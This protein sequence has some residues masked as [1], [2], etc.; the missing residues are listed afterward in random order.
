MQKLFFFLISDSFHQ[1]ILYSNKD[2]IKQEDLKALN[3]VCDACITTLP[4]ES[5]MSCEVIL[6]KP[7][8][9]VIRNTEAYELTSNLEVQKI[10]PLTTKSNSTT[11]KSV[12][13]QEYDTNVS[14]KN[15]KTQINEGKIHYVPDEN[16]DWDDEDP[17]D[18]LTCELENVRVSSSKSKEDNEDD[19]KITSAQTTFKL[20][21][22]NQ[23]RIAK[24]QLLLPHTR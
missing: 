20:T 3:H 10:R 18:D 4:H 15:G 17:D 14:S 13:N 12:E 19:E 1:F 5:Y 7:S 24:N 11:E 8:G 21:L 22:T 9:K 16:D 6:K 23:E 2:I